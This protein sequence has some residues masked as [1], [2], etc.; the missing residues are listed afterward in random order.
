MGAAPSYARLLVR[1]RTV[2]A[3]LQIFDDAWAAARERDLPTHDAMGAVRTGKLAYYRSVR[4]VG[5][6]IAAAVARNAPKLLVDGL[7]ALRD[8]LKSAGAKTETLG[9]IDRDAFARCGARVDDACRFDGASAAALSGAIDRLVVGRIERDRAVTAMLRREHTF[10]APRFRVSEL[11]RQL[12]TL[13]Y[14]V[15]AGP[16]RRRLQ[17]SSSSANVS[18]PAV[19]TTNGI[20]LCTHCSLDPSRLAQLEES[21]RAWG[22]ALSVAVFPRLCN[23]EAEV[24]G[25][26]TST[27]R[28]ASAVLDQLR[29]L[30]MLRHRLE[31][32]LPQCTVTL[33]VL[34]L[35]NAADDDEAMHLNAVGGVGA[36]GPQCR[37]SKCGAA[38]QAALR[39]RIVAAERHASRLYPINALRNAAVRAARS[40]LVLCVDVDL[41][42]SRGLRERLTEPSDAA[43]LRAQTQMT[44]PTVFVLPAFETCGASDALPR[45]R[46]A[47][48]TMVERG[49]AGAFQAD[50]FPGG[51]RATQHARWL[52]RCCLRPYTVDPR[53]GGGSA[54]A[55]E[56][57]SPPLVGCA[58]P[59]EAAAHTFEPFILAARSLLL[60]DGAAWDERFTG[61]GKNKIEHAMRLTVQA[62]AQWV[63]LPHGFLIARAHARSYVWELTYGVRYNR[64]LRWRTQALYL[65][66]VRDACATAGA[67]AM[68][69]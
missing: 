10:S 16:C 29:E 54:A 25:V 55:T 61:Y 47:L 9:M 42:S 28:T 5:K 30:E 46:G 8:E 38:E 26:A 3:T 63:V 60:S 27:C 17:R 39:R 21:A 6:V 18:V 65:T 1:M 59:A 2:G 22:G 57:A 34:T 43:W 35:L 4:H 20:T 49:E 68:S 66:A 50:L 23:A 56:C 31:H 53:G 11:P 24:G 7:A 51:H 33:T 37:G 13:P 41:V 45:T 52:S 32:S 14:S 12:D 58:T 67:F 64:H 40:E 69:S 36:S 62:R 19:E 15:S 48:H 44:P